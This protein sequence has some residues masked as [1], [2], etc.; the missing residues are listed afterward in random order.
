MIGG[1][2]RLFCQRDKAKTLEVR[3]YQNGDEARVVAIWKACGLAVAWNEPV[4]DV[5]RKLRH[6]SE[7]FLVGVSRGEIIAT[8][9]FGYDG[10]RGS[11]NY[12]AEAAG[13][14]NQGVARE[15]MQ[16]LAAR[17][18]CLECPK[19]NLM[20]RQSNPQAER[21]YHAVDY[22]QDPVIVVSKRL[23]NDD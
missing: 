8:V 7:V 15:L 21:F 18:A 12:L 23:L 17:L 3:A 19:I 14:Q 22:K 2:C 9:M 1:S 20:I 4:R 5:E 13:H 6:S 10:H 16:V 11:V